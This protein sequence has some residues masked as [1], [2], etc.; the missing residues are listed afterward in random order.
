MLGNGHEKIIQKKEI[1]YYFV[2]VG[3]IFK[4]IYTN[5]QKE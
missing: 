3:M 4:E 1:I 5:I 2:M